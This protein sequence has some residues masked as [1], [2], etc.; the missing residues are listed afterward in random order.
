MADHVIPWNQGGRTDL[1]NLVS[2]CASC[3]YGKDRF[4]IEQLGI[5]NPFKRQPIID[6]WMGLTD[7]I[8]MLRTIN[9]P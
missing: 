8:E 6:N 4:T 9:N 2:A 3:N 7:K 5:E 1:S